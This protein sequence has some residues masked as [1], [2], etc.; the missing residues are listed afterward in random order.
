MKQP[1]V[2]VI[3]LCYNHASFVI[4]SIES[5]LNQ[6]YSYIE[7]IVVDDCSDDNSQRIIS[8]YLADKPEITFLPLPKNVGNCA[9]FNKGL[10]L[11]KGKYVIDLA[12]DD[13]LMP[14]RIVKQ[15]EAFE[16]LNEQYGVVFSDAWL[17]NEQ[18][19]Q[20]KTYYPRKDGKLL[21]TIPSGDVYKHLIKQAFICTPT[22]MMRKAV[23]DELGGYDE[24]L[25][26]EDYDFWVRSGRKYYYYYQD[27]IL[28]KKRVLSHSHRKSFYKK[29]F[30]PHL[31]STLKICWK[32]YKLNQNED[33]RA[34]LAVS[35][36]YHMRQALYMELFDLVNAY[37]ELLKKTA[38]LS[39]IDQFIINLAKAKVRLHTLY[40][41]YLR[42]RT[43]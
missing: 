12:A 38:K 31:K 24:T 30:N 8:N 3:C 14:E 37:A 17:I 20:L 10:A 22:M 29:T 25:S 42:L 6:S 27:L 2:S 1:L 18:G 32:A 16:H 41:Y 23:L 26:Y 19:E 4:E 34:A 7:L 11:A 15:V 40:Q 13:V 28:T 36:R 43:Q 9:A 35:V 21:K 39:L 33:E 5:V